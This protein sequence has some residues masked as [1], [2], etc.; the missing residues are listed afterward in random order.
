MLTPLQNARRFS[1]NSFCNQLNDMPCNLARIVYLWQPSSQNLGLLSSLNPHE[2]NGLR[3]GEIEACRERGG[4]LATCKF[5]M[6]SCKLFSII[7][8]TIPIRYDI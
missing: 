6:D 1:F 7:V 5:F 2:R 8:L 3:L 4:A